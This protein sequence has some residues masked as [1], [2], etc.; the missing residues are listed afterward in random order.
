MI[1]IFQSIIGRMVP[2]TRK[3]FL[4]KKAEQLKKEFVE[5]LG[6]NGVFFYPD[7]P[8]TAHKHFEI[9]HKLVDTSYMMIF[10]ALGL[11]SSSCVIGVDKN[12]MPSKLMTELSHI[13]FYF[14]F[15]FFFSWYSGC[16]CTRTGSSHFR[17]CQGN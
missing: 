14:E 1:G 6:D 2:E 15:S 11:P 17:C 10:N 16:G 12:N 8:N 4:N 7:F 5:L 3:K 13:V 9:F